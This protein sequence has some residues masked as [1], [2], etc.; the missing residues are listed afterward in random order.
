MR[1]WG[2]GWLIAA[3]FIAGSLCGCSERV[4]FA[5]GQEMTGGDPE[6]G[7]Q[8]IVRHDCHSCH[9]I[10]GIEGERD[11]QGPALDHWASRKSIAQQWPN[12]PT[13]L[14]NWIRH[15]EQLRPGT[16]MKMMS[17]NEKDARDIAAYLYSLN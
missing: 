12:T 11:V 10:P 16:T 2:A 5:Q 14:E 13:N 7:R 6:A 17:I 8:A 3:S 1:A 15:S 4:H 9:V